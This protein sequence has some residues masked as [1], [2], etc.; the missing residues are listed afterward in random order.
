MSEIVTFLERDE[1]M[2]TKECE[3]EER[4]T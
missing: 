1:G 4:I 3:R 2:Y